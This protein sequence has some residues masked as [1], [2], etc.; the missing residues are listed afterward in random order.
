MFDRASFT[1][2]LL[3]IKRCINDKIIKDMSVCPY[4]MNEIGAYLENIKTEVMG[5]K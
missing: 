4:A 1:K 3:I 5:N 2:E